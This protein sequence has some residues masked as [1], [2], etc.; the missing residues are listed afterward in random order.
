MLAWSP[1]SHKQSQPLPYLE[2]GMP[3]GLLLVSQA[4]LIS[5]RLFYTVI[6]PA[7][8]F[9]LLRCSIARYNVTVVQLSRLSSL[10]PWA[11]NFCYRTF[12]V[13]GFWISASRFSVSMQIFSQRNPCRR[14]LQVPRSG[15]TAGLL[16]E[17]LFPAFCLF[18]SAV[19]F[20]ITL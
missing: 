4:G 17:D 2:V 19:H 11:P 20:L 6:S 12:L 3:L 10:M 1:V 14:S 7:Y 18:T 8:G 13:W 5:R 9:G 15:T 16:T